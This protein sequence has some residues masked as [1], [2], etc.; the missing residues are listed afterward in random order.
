MSLAA[1]A[2]SFILQPSAHGGL[3][4]YVPVLRQRIELPETCMSRRVLG[5]SCPG[6]G[7]T[8]SFVAVAGGDLKRAL[9]QNPMGP[10]VFL[11]VV[12]QVPYRLIEYAGWGESRPLWKR[13]TAHL[14]IVTYALMI[15]L[16]AAWIVRMV[17]WWI[18]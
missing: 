6:C 2:G 16:I 14:H 17:L 10:I 4:L 13:V 15:A 18:P 1:L 11:L 8:R 5:I 9:S 12:L 7:L 3:Y